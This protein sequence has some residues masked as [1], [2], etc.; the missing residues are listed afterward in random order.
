[1]GGLW[2]VSQW[3]TYPKYT[4][5]TVLSWIVFCTDIGF[6]FFLLMVLTHWIYAV[7]FVVWW[8]NIW[9]TIL[10]SVLIKI[11]TSFALLH[12]LTCLLTDLIT[13]SA[14]DRALR[15]PSALC[16]IFQHFHTR[17]CDAHRVQR[18]IYLND[19]DDLGSVSYMLQGKTAQDQ[20]INK[21]YAGW[22]I[23]GV[24]Q[25]KMEMSLFHKVSELSTLCLIAVKAWRTFCAQLHP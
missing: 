13:V 16:W 21:K 18:S 20:A 24:T 1:M 11:W 15:H 12:H 19:D 7:P 22:D 14:Q 9:S 3:L 10:R 5:I 25:K 23:L 2:D 4:T 6:F 17:R 8:G